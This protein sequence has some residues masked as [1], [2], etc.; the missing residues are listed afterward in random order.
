MP[1]L[2]PALAF[3]SALVAAFEC[4]GFTGT[5]LWLGLCLC[6]CDCAFSLTGPCLGSCMPS[7]LLTPACDFASAFI[8]AFACCCVCFSKFTLL[9]HEDTCGST[10]SS[11]NFTILLDNMKDTNC[12]LYTIQYHVCTQQHGFSM[13]HLQSPMAIACCVFSCPCTVVNCLPLFACAGGC[14]IAPARWI[15]RGARCR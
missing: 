4:L 7:A 5:Y 3:L 15:S 9:P 10:S 6:L 2:A 12:S 13:T 11:C 1:L 8:F 14:D